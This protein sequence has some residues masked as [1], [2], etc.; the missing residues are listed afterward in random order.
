MMIY[1]KRFL[2]REYS[3]ILECRPEPDSAEMATWINN[4]R[5]ASEVVKVAAMT[6][7]VNNQVPGQ[8]THQCTITKGKIWAAEKLLDKISVDRFPC[9]LIVDNITC[10][11]PH[12]IDGLY[13]GSDMTSFRNKKQKQN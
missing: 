13:L 5:R 8:V 10:V 6:F 4:L 3:H 2:S 12:N 11:N 9:D 1:L 7:I